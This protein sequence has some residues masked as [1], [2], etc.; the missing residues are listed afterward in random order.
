MSEQ[1]Y[2]AYAENF[3]GKYTYEIEQNLLRTLEETQGI[4]PRW[5]A[6]AKTH[7]EEGFMAFRKA[8]KSKEKIMEC[9]D[10]HNEE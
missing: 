1:N 3:E 8:F 10:R 4:E 5:K 6:I 9:N 2:P 7:F